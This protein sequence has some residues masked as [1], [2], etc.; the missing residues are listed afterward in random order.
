VKRAAAGKGPTVF[1]GTDD[2]L[3]PL[4]INAETGSTKKGAELLDVNHGLATV[5]QIAGLDPRALLQQDP[6]HHLLA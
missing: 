2:G 6:I 5:L 1:G 3:F 4:E